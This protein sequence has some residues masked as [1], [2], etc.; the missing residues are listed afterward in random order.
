MRRGAFTLVEVMVALGLMTALAVLVFG[1]LMSVTAQRDR[2][3]AWAADLH[4]GTVL[5]DRIEADLTHCIAGRPG[6]AGVKGDSTRLTVLTRGVTLSVD[7]SAPVDVQ[8]AT[9]GFDEASSVVRM[10]RGDGWEAGSGGEVVSD[11]MERMTV[12]YHDGRGWTDSFDSEQAGGLPVAVEVALWFHRW[13]WEPE[14]ASGAAGYMEA[15][16]L[17]GDA[18]LEDELAGDRVNPDEMAIGAGALR[19]PDRV[20]VFAIPDGGVEEG[21]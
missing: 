9:Y 18:M 3:R 14:T 21:G 13:D 4:A 10:S 5:L 11:R 19:E 16:G 8:W 20:R 6:A 15:G 12:R 17:E 1:M 7:G 2:A